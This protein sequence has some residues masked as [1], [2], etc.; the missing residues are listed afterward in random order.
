MVERLVDMIFTLSIVE[1]IGSNLT[2][3]I[4]KNTNKCYLCITIETAICK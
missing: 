2:Q 4:N 1:L 3:L